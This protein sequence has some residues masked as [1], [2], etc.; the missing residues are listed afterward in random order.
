MGGRHGSETQPP[1]RAALQFIEARSDDIGLVAFAGE[2]FARLPLT[3]DGF[4]VQ[5]AVES[6]EVGLLTDGTDIAGAI[7]AGA[8]LLDDSPHASKVLILV[9]DGAHNKA[10]VLPDLAARAAAA[11]GVT[12][13]PVAIGQ[14]Q[15]RDTRAMETVLTQ[16]ARITG[17]RY[18]KATDVGALEEI[19]AEIDRHGH[20]PPGVA[21]GGAAMT[22]DRPELLIVA[23]ASA[24]ALAIFVALQWRR[25]RRLVEAYG[26]RAPSMR[27]LGR[28][29]TRLPLGRLAVV[30]VGASAMAL[31]ATGPQ[32]DESEA[33]PPPTPIDLVITVDVSHSMSAADVQGGRI[34]QARALVDEIVAAG[35]ADRIALSIFAD[36]PYEL[37][38]ITDDETVISF[39]APWVTPTLVGTRDQ[40]TSMAAAV[41]AARRQ[42]DRRPREGARRIVLVVSDG[43]VHEGSAEALDSVQAISDDGFEVWSAGAG[44]PEGAALYVLGSDDAPLLYDGAAVVAG[45][46]GAFLEELAATGRGR[47]HDISSEDGVRS[48]VDDLGSDRS[49]DDG[50]GPEVRGPVF[51][52]LIFS[53]V[54]LVLD[55]A[56]DAG[57]LG[58]ALRSWRFSAP[59]AAPRPQET[60]RH[61]RR[62]RI[63]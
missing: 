54:L 21:P 7:A 43:E 10:G 50:Q 58:R 62:E 34:A 26:G 3:H 52:L 41:G 12:I 22:F 61:R 24:I 46:D 2:A 57:L 42:W 63:A 28:D 32:T 47:F 27:L 36:W 53:L 14:E 51:W 11:V 19:Y 5:D 33:P 40:G 18:F 8:G 9:T 44:T 59:W 38:P 35:V 55:A 23:P 56:L 15:G 6:L 48:L 60:L 4:V 16:A 45:Y 30:A 13:Y 17:G 49:P 29:L 1:R 20:P 31:A 25:G 37:V 39:F